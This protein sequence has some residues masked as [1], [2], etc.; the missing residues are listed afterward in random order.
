M[1]SDTELGLDQLD[2]VADLSFS[3]RLIQVWLLE[4]NV[5]TNFH[6]SV[7]FGIKT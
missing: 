3:N 4:K 6:G 2:A 1:A 5:L 7:Y